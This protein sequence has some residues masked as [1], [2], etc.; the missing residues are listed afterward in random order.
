MAFVVDKATQ[1]EVC[2]RVLRFH[3]V[4]ATPPI[5]HT[6]LSLIYQESIT[7]LVFLLA[8]T[9][10]GNFPKKKKKKPGSNLETPGARKMT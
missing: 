5:L 10:V 4:I 3:P 9:R 6:S 1:G 7:F 2:L 8:M